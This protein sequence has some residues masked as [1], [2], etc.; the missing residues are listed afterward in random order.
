M[1]SKI[2]I[3]RFKSIKEIDLS[4][5]KVNLFIGGNGSG[6]SNILE[7]IGL[8]SACLDRG[9]SDVDL[10]MKGMR[11]TPPELMKSS[12]KNEDLPRTFDIKATLDDCIEYKS[13]ISSREDGK[14]LS[15]FSENCRADGKSIFGRSNRGAT[16][17][18]VAH[19]DRLD[20]QRGLWDQIKATYTVSDDIL[21][22][23][24]EYSKYAI[25]SPQTDFLRGKKTGNSSIFPI[26]LH[27]EGLSEALLSFIKKHIK[28]EQSSSNESEEIAQLM[29]EAMNL[30]WLPGWASS[31]TLKSRNNILT[32]NDM[33]EASEQTVVFKDKFMHRMRNYLSVYDSS[34][35][36]LFLLFAALLL[37]HPD[38]PRIFAFDNVDNALNPR[39]TR[40][41]VEK[42]ISI[43]SQSCE[44]NL[45]VGAKQVFM[46]SHNPTS[47]DAF[48]LFN[49]DQ[50][51]FVVSRNKKGHTCATRLQ[52]SPNITK[53]DWEIAK[54]GK[55]LS[56]LWLD[57]EIDGAYGEI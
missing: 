11:I 19:A 4:F 43:T 24:N 13:V 2:F 51:V 52:P 1:L 44:K 36:T 47:L 5:G 55:N 53:E 40:K 22:S 6:K 29:S 31:V 56:Q 35:G 15:F 57:G 34:E 10:K 33:I 27:G 48:D 37:A 16:A 23:F 25:F 20:K 45:P 21:K 42:I 28:Y 32:S 17:T 38:S 26:G 3:N 39:L 50:R 30:V 7:A 14:F 46:T 12:F 54:N 41:L 49:P 8:S 9:L 18:G